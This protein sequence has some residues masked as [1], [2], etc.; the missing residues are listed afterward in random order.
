MA[1]WLR[2]SLRVMNDPTTAVALLIAGG[3]LGYLSSLNV[4]RAQHRQALTL[5]VADEYFSA[6]RE[7]VMLV[8]E[9]A[10]IKLLD[11]ASKP[12]WPQK[13]D[14]VGNLFYRHFD[15]L[16]SPVLDRLILLHV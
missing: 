12:Q 14:A 9:L 7:L 16:P 8:S 4:A 2:C 10:D 13:A 1:L 5:R 11:E 3:M 6:R 15:L